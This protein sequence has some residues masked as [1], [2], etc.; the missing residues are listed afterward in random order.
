MIEVKR[1]EGEP[2]NAFIFR[3]SK[4]IRQSGVLREMKRRR[5]KDRNISK[6]KRKLSAIHR[7]EK[8]QEFEKAK[9]AGLV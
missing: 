1:K 3:F 2:I 5:Y 9:K 8:R 4:K 6:A 7:E